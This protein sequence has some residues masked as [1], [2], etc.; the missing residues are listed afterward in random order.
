[1][2]KWACLFSVLRSATFSSELYGHVVLYFKVEGFSCRM[3]SK[4]KEKYSAQL[5][6]VAS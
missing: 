4:R 5:I 3:R 2:L 6:S 1:M